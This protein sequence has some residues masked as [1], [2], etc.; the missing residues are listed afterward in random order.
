[1][2]GAACEVFPYACIGG[3]T[4]DLKYAGGNP[5][6]RIGDRNVFREYVTLHCATK[7]GDATRLGSDNLLLATCHVAH[8]CVLGDHIIMSNGAAGA[9][10]TVL[11]ALLDPG[12][13]VIVLRPYFPEYRFYVENHGGRVVEVET[14]EHFVP[15]PERIARA[16]TPQT[17]ALILNSPNN[18]TGAVYAAEILAAIHKIV[19]EPMLVLSDEPYRPIVFDGITPPETPRPCPR[20]W[21]RYRRRPPA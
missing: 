14:D 6:L 10:N 5:G 12:D 18:P 17:K 19:R 20:C 3:K 15:D 1:M 8:D 4:Q 21:D 7:D 9:L 16:I 2:L 13:E 11:K